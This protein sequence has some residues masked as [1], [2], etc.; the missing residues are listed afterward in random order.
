VGFEGTQVDDRIRALLRETG[1]GSVILFARNLIHAEQCQELIAGLRASV[2]W[3]LLLCVDQEGGAVVR[4][5]EGI[6]VFPGN[7]ALRASENLDLA[8][9]QGLETGRQLLALGFD[10]NLAPVVDVLISPENGGLGLRSFGADREAL[11]DFSQALVK[12]QRDAGLGSC[13]KHFPGLG[14]ALV[15]PHVDMSRFEQSKAELYE[16]HL[17]VYRRLFRDQRLLSVMSTHMLI[18]ELDAEEPV[19]FSR[20]LAQGLLREELGFDGLLISDDLEMGGVKRSMAESALAAAQ[21]SHD[22]MPIC[23]TEEG[24]RAAAQVLNRAL[25]AG[26]LDLASHEKAVERWE[27]MAAQSCRLAPELDLGPGDA[28]AR[29]IAQASIHLHGDARALLPIPATARV[30]ILAQP[31]QRLV[32]IEEKLREDF[33]GSLAA[34]FQGIGEVQIRS[35]GEK[36]SSR[37]I[38]VHL[39]E[40]RGFDRVL[41]LCWNAREVEG[42][43]FLLASACHTLGARLIVVHLR[44]PHDQGLVPAGTTALS[45]FGARLG[46][47]KVLAEVLRGSAPALGI[48]PRPFGA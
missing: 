18:P 26:E 35:L 6:T 15:D 34:V 48:L 24:Q 28:V 8:W 47:L 36:L 37:E 43:R 7:L 2:D 5:T 20:R 27:A 44:N 12:G 38:Q 32:G 4:L 39:A 30:L 21:A 19:T 22:L 11:V 31:P 29:E 16:I 13:L 17:E 3:P 46:Q 41:L 23:H 25:K 10:L 45:S 1:A 42:M 40:A 33:L 14:A 9:R